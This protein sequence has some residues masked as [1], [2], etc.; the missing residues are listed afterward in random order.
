MKA[1]SEDEPDGGW[2]IFRSLGRY[3]T[4]YA[5]RA[6]V[7]AV[8][9]GSNL[10]EDAIYPITRVDADGAKLTGANRYRIHF[11]TGDLPPSTLSGRSRCTAPAS[12]S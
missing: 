7:A 10:P 8:G 12:S 6:L 9:L 4:D 5:T 11:E 3:G 1:L 2:R